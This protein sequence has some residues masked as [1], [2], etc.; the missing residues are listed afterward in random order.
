VTYSSG[1]LRGN[2]PAHMPQHTTLDLAAGKDLGQNVQLRFSALN[3]TDALFLTGFENSFA[4]THYANPREIT[5]QVKI[6]FH[7]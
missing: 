6:K 1:F 2:G 4:G 5:G 7:Y 3:V